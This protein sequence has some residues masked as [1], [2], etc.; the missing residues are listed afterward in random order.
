M[1][2]RHHLMGRPAVRMSSVGDLHLPTALNRNRCL[3]NDGQPLYRLSAAP[4]P[5]HHH[6][7]TDQIKITH[8]LCRT[9]KNPQH[10]VDALNPSQTLIQQQQHQPQQPRPTTITPIII[11]IVKANRQQTNQRRYQTDPNNQSDPNHHHHHHLKV[12]NF[13][14][15]HL[16]S[17]SILNFPPTKQHRRRFSRRRC[18]LSAINAM[19]KS[20]LCVTSLALISSMSVHRS[21]AKRAAARA[22]KWSRSSRRVSKI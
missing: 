22:M 5:H 3:S 18:Q 11:I 10:V 15:H 4:P 19:G 16:P 7:P 12:N 8:R 21:M 6:F 20:H 13:L 1:F 9:V 17:G 2:R 14:H